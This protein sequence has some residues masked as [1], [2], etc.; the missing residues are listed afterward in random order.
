MPRELRHHRRSSRGPAL[1][2][3]A[4]AIWNKS[5]WE[6]GDYDG[7]FVIHAESEAG[8]DLDE[9]TDI[10]VDDPEA[11]D[12]LHKHFR[13]W[14]ECFDIDDHVRLWLEAKE[15]GV[16]GVPDVVTLVDDARSIKTTLDKV[17]WALTCVLKDQQRREWRAVRA[18]SGAWRRRSPLDEAIEESVRDTMQEGA[19]E[20]PIACNE[21]TGE[22]R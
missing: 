11:L 18:G 10:R 21:V 15:N 17:D 13:S 1:E 12:K 7:C 14:Y 20:S 6:L 9:Y 2:R 5:G 4:W 16:A 19:L 22:V 3:C 8:E